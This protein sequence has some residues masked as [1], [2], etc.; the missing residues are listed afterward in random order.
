[1]GIVMKRIVCAAAVLAVI[2]ASSA[3]ATT[4]Y[5]AT[6]GNDSTGNGSI[7]SP[8]A[9][10]AKAVSVMSAGDVTYLRGG[11]YATSA[12]INMTAFGTSASRY[13]ITNYSGEVPTLDCSSQSGSLEGIRITGAYWQLYGL[14]ITNAAH[15]GINIR[16]GTTALMGSFN[17]VE[18]CVVTGNRNS[19]ILIGSNSGSFT[20]LPSSNSVINCDATRNYDAPEGGNAD[21]F[22]A[23]WTIGPGNLFIGCRSWQNSDDGWDLWMGINPVVISN[24]WTWQN[25][26]NVWG[27]SSFAGNGNGFKLGGNFVAAN[28]HLIYGLSYQN[29]GNGGN[30][31]DQNNNTGNLTVDQV[32]SWANVNNN[33]DLSHDTNGGNESH[34]VR[35][36]VSLLGGNSGTFTSNTIQQSNSWQVVTSPSVNSNDFVSMDASQL[37]LPRQADGS[38]PVITLVHPVPGGR[39]VD[40]GIIIPGYPYNGSAPDLGAFETVG[41][42]APAASFTGSPTNGTAPLAMMFTDGS[43]GSITNRYWTFGDG[44]T[45][46]TTSTSVGHTYNA[47]TYTVSL[48]VSGTGGTNTFT[49]SNYI[50]ATNIAPPVAGFTAT[51]TSGVEPLMV[52]FT[53]TS[54][55]PITNLFWN[56]GDNTTTNTVGGAIFAHAYVAGIYTVTLTASNSDGTSVLVS[57]NLI[58]AYTAFQAWQLQYFGCMACPQADPNA[59]PLGKGMSNTNQFLAGLNPTDSHSAL[60]IVSV[61][62]EGNDIAITWTTAGV[63]TNAVQATIG[64]GSGGYSTN[65]VDI[66]APIVI[67]A[68]GDATTN[69]LD[70]GAATNWPARFYRVRLVP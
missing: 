3:F 20:A 37:A 50:V 12:Q 13:T 7:G 22:S 67:P 63:R 33:F 43:T 8:Y 55:G 19:G 57:N 26:S 10:L 21:G 58:T 25:G 53:D 28:H 38:L 14:V 32:T 62:P 6:N 45:I 54:S 18:R 46:N 2:G 35:N 27:S 29:V 51:P 11:T 34:L 61:T 70:P 65:F 31:V 59:D 15:N 41:V 49:R 17:R 4:Y 36:C 52:T 16:G 68:D 64:D 1:M 40:K 56:L 60:R 30:G 69:Y 47:G 48:T 39:L 42:S 24:C 5:V 23:K 44:G 66:S 9:T